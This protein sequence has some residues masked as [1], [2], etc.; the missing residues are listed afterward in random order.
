MVEHFQGTE[1]LLVGP[2]SAWGRGEMECLAADQC[3][4]LEAC[5]PVRT[6]KVGRKRSS[7]TE[8]AGRV[9][10]GNRLQRPKKALGAWGSTLEKI[11]MGVHWGEH[12]PLSPLYEQR[13]G[14]FWGGEQ[15]GLP[16]PAPF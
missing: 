10:S 4:P 15:P 16:L 7:R 2:G 13:E 14:G 6:R 8:P 9:G 3:F 11:G 1:R 12:V 5:P